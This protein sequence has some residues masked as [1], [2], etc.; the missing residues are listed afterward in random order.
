MN[1]QTNPTQ[2]KLIDLVGAGKKVR[3]SFYRDKEFWYEV[4]GTGFT[5]PVPLSD[6]DNPASRATLLAEDKA[7]LFMRWI[8]KYLDSINQAWE[9]QQALC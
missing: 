7:I 4:E 8:R 1:V 5:F 6:V 3:F 2:V 9:E